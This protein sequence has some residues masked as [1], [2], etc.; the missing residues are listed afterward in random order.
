MQGHFYCSKHQVCCVKY[1]EKTCRLDWTKPKHSWVYL[2]CNFASTSRVAWCNVYVIAHHMTKHCSKTKIWQH[3]YTLCN[4]VLKRMTWLHTTRH[5]CSGE[6]KGTWDMS[7]VHRRQW[8]PP[9]KKHCTA[10]V[11]QGNCHVKV[12]S[13]RFW[14]QTGYWTSRIRSYRALAQS[15]NTATYKSSYCD[16]SMMS[17][18]EGLAAT[19]NALLSCWLMSSQMTFSDKFA[20]SGTPCSMLYVSSPE[21][22]SLTANTS[23]GRPHTTTYLNELFDL[24][25]AAVQ[26]NCTFGDVRTMPKAAGQH[27]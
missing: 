18:S 22:Q 19:D 25:N 8:L 14:A 15:V 23:L 10:T 2:W 5:V 12:V 9:K 3:A 6:K 24:D 27:N 20:S 1:T 21:L 26:I 16:M 17:V 13:E 11:S 7:G 4:N